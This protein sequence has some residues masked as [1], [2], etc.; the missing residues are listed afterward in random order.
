MPTTY[1]IIVSGKP[2]TDVIARTIIDECV[3]KSCDVLVSAGYI[4]NDDD[5]Y[6]FDLNGRSRHLDALQD[7]F[8][9]HISQFISTAG[10]A[11][12]TSHVNLFFL[13]N[14]YGENDLDQSAFAKLIETVN[15]PTHGFDLVDIWHV[16][17]GY[18]TLEPQNVVAR[19]ADEVMQK[20]FTTNIESNISTLYVGSQYLNG[21]A[22][23]TSKEHHDFHLPRM[24]A[25]FMLVAS[26]AK[27]GAGIVT[28]AIPA[29]SKSKAFSFGQAECMY[30]ASDV[31]K[32]LGLY[33][34]EVRIKLELDGTRLS[35]TFPKGKRSQLNELSK[36][37]SLPDNYSQ[38]VKEDN[39]LATIDKLITSVFS[40]FF[41][42]DSYL[43]ENICTY[44]E[45]H[46]ALNEYKASCGT[47]KE[48]E[49]LQIFKDKRNVYESIREKIV[50]LDFHHFL[51]SKLAGLTD[52]K[53]KRGKEKRELD[54]EKKNR[55][56]FKRIIE[57]FTG[58]SARGN[59]KLT[60]LSHQLED[61]D[62]EIKKYETAITA[63]DLV[64]KL[65]RSRKELID[66]KAEVAALENRLITIQIDI[67]NF[68]LTEFSDAI[69]IISIGHLRKY[70]SKNTEN[71][72]NEIIEEYKISIENGSDDLD[73]A[74]NRVVAREQEKYETVDWNN[75]FEFIIIDNIGQ[76]YKS[77]QK[78]SLPCIHAEN[79]DGGKIFSKVETFV[80]A[81][82]EGFAQQNL[83][84]MS[85]P[86]LPQRSTSVKDKICMLQIVSLNGQYVD[87]LIGKTLPE[88]AEPICDDNNVIIEEIVDDSDMIDISDNQ[89]KPSLN[90]GQKLLQSLN[91]VAAKVYYLDKGDLKMV[92]QCNE[93]IRGKK[94]IDKVAQSPIDSLTGMRKDEILN[95]YSLF[96]KFGISYNPLTAIVK[97]L[98]KQ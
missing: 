82:H 92:K 14:P 96:L 93:L 39:Y 91:F 45:V 63:E 70:F 60:E 5:S 11:A 90:D 27:T 37:F 16:V 15:T 56:F 67:K 58:A 72:Q 88:E 62:R 50:H 85:V 17:L 43:G 24:L 6:S 69:P 97:E 53:E 20:I 65:E 7:G 42:K 61:L 81:N 25:D 38:L 1:F 52:L 19:P 78:K 89:T 66:L 36:H 41:G 32:L 80:F 12:Q 83:S 77:L 18:D 47:N 10:L 84:E 28:A 30:I 9:N 31:Q 48:Q 49:K 98:N 76:T 40:P 33:L 79:C 94:L 8:R 57:F 13:D 4:N 87:S 22:N 55:S 23:F 2:Q 21:G 3:P 29:Y 86:Y 59:S 51:S 35:D 46:K 68:R 95:I 75:P 54:E 26:D 34:D 74:F 73:S 71:F 44:N 64:C